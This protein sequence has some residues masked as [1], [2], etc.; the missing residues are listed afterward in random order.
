M[1]RS[2][3]ADWSKEIETDVL[4]LGYGCAGSI[5]AITA[6]DKGSKVL[7]L[8]KMDRGGGATFLSNGGIW[9]PTSME[10]AQYLYDISAGTTP[11]DLLE[12]FVEEAMKIEDYI[13]NTLDG[14]FERWVSQEIAASFPPL[15]RPSWPKVP[16]G[17]RVTQIVA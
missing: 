2:I 15:T 1:M 3:K 12:T 8:E 6:H 9:V 16:T 13:A 7:I 17:K 10:F 5:A 11:M 4:V 14:V